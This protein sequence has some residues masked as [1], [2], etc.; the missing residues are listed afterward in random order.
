MIF[1]KIITRYFILLGQENFKEGGSSWVGGV[2]CWIGPKL[3]LCGYKNPKNVQRRSEKMSRNLQNHFLLELNESL[4]KC[5][6]LFFFRF[7]SYRRRIQGGGAKGLYA[8]PPWK[9]AEV[10]CDLFFGASHFRSKTVDLATHFQKN[11]CFTCIILDN[12]SHKLLKYV[13]KLRQ[14]RSGRMVFKKGEANECYML[15]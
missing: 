6:R 15:N 4:I 10:S 13:L 9:L 3:G 12:S 2:E 11:L 5:I 8:S 7:S 1:K 14:I